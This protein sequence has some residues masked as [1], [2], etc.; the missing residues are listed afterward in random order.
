MRI[1]VFTAGSVRSISAMVCC[2]FMSSFS[3]LKKES[4]NGF[5][6][7]SSSTFQLDSLEYFLVYLRRQL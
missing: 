7:R 4:W 5:V 2:V 6:K 1:S 3:H